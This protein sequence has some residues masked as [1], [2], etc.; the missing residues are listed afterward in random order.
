MAKKE[1]RDREEAP[2]TLLILSAI[3]ALIGVWYMLVPCLAQRADGSF[4]A[5]LQHTS[6]LVFVIFQPIL[7]ISAV[8]AAYRVWRRYSE[9]TILIFWVVAVVACADALFAIP[10]SMPFIFAK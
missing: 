4:S 10:L 9:T 5:H 3:L 2:I 1:A 7:G 8:Y 6:Y